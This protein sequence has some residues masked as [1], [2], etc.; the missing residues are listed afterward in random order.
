VWVAG[1]DPGSWAMGEDATVV[2]PLGS[3]RVSRRV[4][5]QRGHEGSIS[6]LLVDAYGTTAVQ[7]EAD[8]L[9][10]RDSPTR[11]VTLALGDLSIRVLLGNIDTHPIAGQPVY[12]AVS[13]DFWQQ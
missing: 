8:L 11:Q 10:M 12:R 6:G 13:F 7:Y 1:D 4:Q 3:T 5:S 9:K 2:A